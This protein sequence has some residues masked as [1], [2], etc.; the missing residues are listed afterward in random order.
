[1]VICWL[2]LDEHPL[3]NWEPIIMALGRAKK[4]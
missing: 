1:M 2:S 3:D 4:R